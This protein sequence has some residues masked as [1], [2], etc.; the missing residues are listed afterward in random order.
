MKFRRRIAL[1]GCALI[2][3]MYGVANA[4]NVVQDGQS[5]RGVQQS[6]LIGGIN[7]A[8]STQWAFSNDGSG[9]LY[10]T[11]ANPDRTF[12][13]KYQS[14]IQNSL[15]RVQQCQAAPTTC[16]WVLPQADSSLAKLT[17]G[18]RHMALLITY[19]LDDSTCEA[20]VGIEVRGH[21]TQNADSVSSFLWRW[22]DVV[23]AAIDTAGSMAT[24][25]AGTSVGLF[26]TTALDTAN[27]AF[28]ERPI[29]LSA[30]NSYRAIY[31]P[32]TNRSTG[33]W[34]QAP[35]TSIKVRVI[36]A[37]GSTACTAWTGKA[38]ARTNLNVD[39]LGWR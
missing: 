5:T 19:T 13:Y 24:T 33:E 30:I 22:R 39:L 34:F 2:L 23:P 26:A 32:I 12:L 3:W 29:V 9:N 14:L 31:L 10:M 7:R 20:L 38:G 27:V 17:L 36:K 18:A 21:M 35:Y 6:I 15:W 37:Y 25:N 11:D 28:F 16:T 4:Q 8:D 1:A